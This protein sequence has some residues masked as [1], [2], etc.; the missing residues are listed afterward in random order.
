MRLD[1]DGLV[2][3]VGTAAVHVVRHDVVHQVQGVVLAEGIVEPFQRV[4][5]SHQALEHAG[6]GV[7]ILIQRLGTVVFRGYEIRGT[8]RDKQQG[9]GAEGKIYLFHLCIHFRN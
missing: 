5:G 7:E 4:I 8:G 3:V 2:T 1:Q 6:L 9:C